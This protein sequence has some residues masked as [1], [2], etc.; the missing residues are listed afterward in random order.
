MVAYSYKIKPPKPESKFSNMF[1]IFIPKIWGRWTQ[2][3]EH[4]F[5]NGLLQPWGKLS[6]ASSDSLGF[7]SRKQGTR[8]NLPTPS[9]SKRW[10]DTLKRKSGFKGTWKLPPANRASSDCFFVGG[11]FGEKIPNLQFATMFPDAKKWWYL[12]CSKPW[13][14]FQIKIS[15]IISL[16]RAWSSKKQCIF[17]IIYFYLGIHE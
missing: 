16:P 15:N 4:I 17:N 12:N 11:S 14:T 13:I 6:S 2:F 10:N 3:D 7:P 5:S 9:E 1:V 8:R